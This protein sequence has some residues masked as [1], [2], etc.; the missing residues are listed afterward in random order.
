MATA[1]DYPLTYGLCVSLKSHLEDKLINN[2]PTE[3]QTMLTY[4]GK[5][6][7]D[8]VFTPSLVKIGRLQDDPTVLS[9][10][11]ALP[12]VGCYI[13]YNDPADMGDG[14]K[15]SIASGMGVAF[16]NAGYDLPDVYE[17]GGGALWWRRFWLEWEAFYIDADTSQVH[18]SRLSS[19]LK[20][21]LEHCINSQS[22]I[23]ENGWNCVLRD[24]LG[25]TAVRS[26]VV[27][28]HLWEGG[29]PDDDYIWRGGVWFQV[30]T[31]RET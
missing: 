7:V 12:S 24:P 20:H 11:T 18:A 27:K 21:T 15:D 31:D 2:V 29:G 30:L 26:Q 1:T 10:S 9:S 16:P 5:D 17:I 3:W 13:H 28:S 25:E 14:W 22:T 23:N 6:G 19:A 4:T 8:R